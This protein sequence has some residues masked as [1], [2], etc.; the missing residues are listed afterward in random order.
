MHTDKSRSPL[1]TDGQKEPKRTARAFRRRLHDSK[2]CVC[3]HNSPGEA[4]GMASETTV[5]R[6]R[7]VRRRT[8]IGLNV[9]V[10]VVVVAAAA[11][12]A[13]HVVG[14]VFTGTAIAEKGWGTR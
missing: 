6:R 1:P 10:V 3:A 9:V 2:T 12:G 14:G 13:T 11:A 7:R 5:V 4:Y 8:S